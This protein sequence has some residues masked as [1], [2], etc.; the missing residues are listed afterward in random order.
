MMTPIPLYIDPGSGSYLVQVIVAGALGIVFFFK[1]LKTY[2]KTL[3]SRSSKK[4]KK[5]DTQVEQAEND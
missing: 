1:N 4:N 3:F 5:T 2:I